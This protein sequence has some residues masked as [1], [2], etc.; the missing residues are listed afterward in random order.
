MGSSTVG[1]MPG[2]KYACKQTSNPTRAARRWPTPVARQAGP[3]G[4]IA[5]NALH[6]L[7]ASYIALQQNLGVGGLDPVLNLLQKRRG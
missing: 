7:A 3:K 4:C 5:Q 2:N 1:T 6:R